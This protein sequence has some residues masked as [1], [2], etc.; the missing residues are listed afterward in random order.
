MMLFAPKLSAA[1]AGDAFTPSGSLQICSVA[2][3][4]AQTI[5]ALA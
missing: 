4:I 2:P 5:A 3:L 1:F